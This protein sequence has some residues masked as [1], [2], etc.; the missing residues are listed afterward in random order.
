MALQAPI[1]G[2]LIALMFR[3]GGDKPMDRAVPLFL[4]CISCIFFGCFNAAREIVNE[5]AIY[6]RER[7]VN[8]KLV[9]YLASKFVFLTVVGIIQVLI[10][11]V[12][13]RFGVG[14][15]GNVLL[16]LAV[17]TGTVM[18]STAMGLVLSSV[19]RSAEA[20]MAIVPIILIPQIM[21][22]GV[23]KP[24]DT[25]PLKVLAT[26]M[27]ARWSNEALVDI[28]HDALE[29]TKKKMT[30]KVPD[31]KPIIHAPTTPP[32]PPRRRGGRPMMRCPQPDIDD[33][34]IK[35]DGEKKEELKAAPVWKK[36]IIEKNELTAHKQQ[37]DLAYLL[38]F[39]LG[40]GVACAAFM[41]LKDR[42]T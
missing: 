39:A 17:L 21:L 7:M 27:I 32:R 31:C 12:L 42:K 26:P 9:P 13:V 35:C 18:A 10:I 28:E 22:A 37:R 1:V 6:H 30:K 24:L 5:L 3:E 11:F 38:L 15:Q 34:D 16:Y 25:D 4:M 23:L 40:L 2:I 29:D 36:G 33:I 14:L 20:A 8:L 19:V 41:L